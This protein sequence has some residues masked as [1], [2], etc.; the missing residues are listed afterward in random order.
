[1]NN[2]LKIVDLNVGTDKEYNKINDAISN[3]TD[4]NT[5]YNIELFNGVYEELIILPENCCLT[6][7]KSSNVILR[8]PT[9]I[10]KNINNTEINTEKQEYSLITCHH[11]T[12]IKN[13]N[14]EIS[15]TNKNHSELIGINSNNKNNISIENIIIYQNSNILSS[16][17]ISGIKI[18]GGEYHLLKNININFPLGFKNMNGIIFDNIKDCKCLHST[19][20]IS[21]PTKNNI[22]FFIKDCYNSNNL[23]I[24]FCNIV[25]DNSENNIGI[26]NI[27]SS[28]NLTYSSV[29]IK[30]SNNMSHGIYLSDIQNKINDN[31][32]D[33]DDILNKKIEL[34]DIFVK[35]LPKNLVIKDNKIM[36]IDDKDEILKDDIGFKLTFIDLGYEKKDIVQLNN[37]NYKIVDVFENEL[38]IEP[39]NKYNNIHINISEK[40][41]DNN[42]G[43]DNGNDNDNGNSNGNNN[44][45][46]NIK[47][48]VKKNKVLLSYNTISTEESLDAKLNNIIF[49]DQLSTIYYSIYEKYNHFFGKVINDY[50]CLLTDK[51]DNNKYISFEVDSD[52]NMGSSLELGLIITIDKILDEKIYGKLS[53]KEKDKT[54]L[55]VY[56]HYDTLKVNHN[57]VCNG[58]CMVWISNING[59]VNYGDLITTSQILGIG[60]VQNDDVYHN[61][62]LGKC[63][64]FVNWNDAHEYFE[65]NNN[66]YSKMLLK[67]LVT[68]A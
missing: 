60:M 19:I 20:N 24:S 41:I 6:S 34:D 54:L 64:Q 39:L 13:I 2:N 43:N 7:N 37:N 9:N 31:I 38:I 44:N 63:I 48:I 47:D 36:F 29:I 27:N 12:T 23:L 45:I 40:D 17:N 49:V 30:G 4:I 55:G 25:I 33:N 46:I 68:T 1:M 3:C 42:N 10:L 14:I 66:L 11:N 16:H 5:F 53:K 21:S 32:D 28:L 26:Y 59:N 57:L 58:E 22:G 8:F 18:Y 62:T 65:F 15:N 67:I 52:V 51:I 61:Y 35:V 56:S 50:S